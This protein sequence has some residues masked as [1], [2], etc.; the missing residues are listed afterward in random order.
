MLHCIPRAPFNPNGLLLLPGSTAPQ[1]FPSSSVLLPEI[2]ISSRV[3]Q[4]HILQQ[5]KPATEP[6]VTAKE[7]HDQIATWV[8][9]HPDGAQPSP[10]EA[11]CDDCRTTFERELS[12]RMKVAEH[13]A[14]EPPPE[15]P[16]QIGTFSATP[17]LA[18]TATSG[19]V[20][21]AV[22][23]D[24]AASIPEPKTSSPV[25]MAGMLAAVGLVLAGVVMLISRGQQPSTTLPIQSPTSASTPNA[26]PL[27]SLNFFNAAATNF[28][29]II[30]GKVKPAMETES[31]EELAE[32]FTEE[33]VAYPVKFPTTPLALA[34]GFVSKHGD[35][36]VAHLVY[37][38]GERTMY[39]FQIPWSVLQQGR[40]FYV[41]QDASQKM[42]A[43]EK[44]MEASRTDQ[45]ITVGKHGDLAIA[46]AANVPSDQLQ[47][48]A[49]W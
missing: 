42:E 33:G 13:T 2:C 4:A 37:R 30:N 39:I 48:L 1:G 3:R 10:T 45:S 24:S 36:A 34:G 44:I 28:G 20:Q 27:P 31:K 7:F 15:T 40:P 9:A 26:K 46:I 29:A 23:A 18:A 41:T 49:K 32:F 5:Q 38:S 43:G 21:P 16:R 8:E 35:L 12:A 19:K 14:T 25:A 6:T 47:Q 11:P 17:G 22:V